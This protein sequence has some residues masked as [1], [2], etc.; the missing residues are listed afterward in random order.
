MI[1]NEI[2]HADLF[3][4][5]LEAD[6][7]LVWTGQPKQGVVFTGMDVIAL[8]FGIIWLLLALVFEAMAIFGD[9]DGASWVFIAIGL[10]FVY[11]GMQMAFIRFFMDKNRRAKTFYAVTDKRA[12][13]IEAYT[14]PRIFTYAQSDLFDLRIN[15]RNGNADVLFGGWKIPQRKRVNLFY[16]PYGIISGFR[17]IADAEKV[18]ALLGEMRSK[19]LIAGEPTNQT[20]A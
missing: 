7:R 3:R 13:V 18:Y 16:W 4:P 15:R 9:E 14:P 19:G 11:I 5:H 10:P 12:I 6:E 2:V 20:N 8:P 17:M 1:G